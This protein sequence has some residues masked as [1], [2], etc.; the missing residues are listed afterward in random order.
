MDKLTTSTTSKK[1]YETISALVAWFALI[2][3]FYLGTGTTINFFTFF[4]NI[5]VALILTSS[6]L[7]PL[8]RPGLFFSR[9]SVQSAIVLYIF[10]VCLVY[11]TVLRGIV[12]L[13]GWRWI[14]DNLLH[15]VV[16][17]LYIIYWF[18]FKSTGKLLW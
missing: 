16:P 14:V 3:Q 12:V 17:V 9:L 10:I 11:N 2:A 7:M 18:A 15:V 8:S 6:L 1:I 4:C 5:L 13:T